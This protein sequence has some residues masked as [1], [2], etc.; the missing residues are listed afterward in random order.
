MT[1]DATTDGPTRLDE[2]VEVVHVL[3]APGGCPWDADQTHES[4]VRYLVEE[5]HE[6]IEAIETGDRD[7]MLEELGDVLYQVLFHADIAA[8]TPGEGFDVQDVA[9]H[10]TA[11]MVG[12]H[13]HVFGDAHAETASDV[14][15]V[16]DDLKAREKP[17]RT[18]VLDGIPMGMPSLALA[19]KLLGR[20]E[21][22]GVTAAG[23][24]VESPDD[25]EG[26]GAL[27]LQLAASARERGLD[28]ER[29]LRGA[30][31][32]LRDDIVTAEASTAGA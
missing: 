21:K 10:M 8:A 4:L 9:A 20:A 14:E 17:A 6:L 15:A 3:R 13:P 27:L 28:P 29:A 32:G 2:L 19:D 1:E 18:S 26:L 7:A 23:P 30:L 16:W 25:E 11:K 12:R 24:A 22:V 5:T 31:R